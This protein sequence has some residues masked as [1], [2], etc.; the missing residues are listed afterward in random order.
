ML[1]WQR[2]TVEVM[3]LKISPAAASESMAYLGMPR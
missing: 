3:G 1:G 2:N